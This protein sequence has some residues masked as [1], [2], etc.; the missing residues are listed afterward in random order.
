MEPVD[1]RIESFLMEAG[2][3]CS[4]RQKAR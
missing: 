2:R 4:S 3:V 1:P